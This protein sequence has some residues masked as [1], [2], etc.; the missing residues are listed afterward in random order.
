[1]KPCLQLRCNC[2]LGFSMCIFP[3]MLHVRTMTTVDIYLLPYLLSYLLTPCRRVLLEKFTVFQLVTKFPSFYGT[4]R[5][6]TAFRSARHI[7]LSWVSL[8]QSITSHPTSWR[9]VLIVSFHLRQVPKSCIFHLVFPTNS[10]Q[11]FLLSLLSP[12]NSYF[13]I[14]S[15]QQYWVGRT[16]HY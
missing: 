12:L 15:P 7:S 9:S 8:I 13:S 10:L 3:Q 2:S 11:K 6:I 14:L 16:S 4:R 1:M 5:F